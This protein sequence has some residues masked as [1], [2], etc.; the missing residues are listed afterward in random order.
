MPRNCT[1]SARAFVGPTKTSERSQPGKT[2][3]ATFIKDEPS[4]FGMGWVRFVMETPAIF[5]VSNVELRLLLVA[6]A[7][8]VLTRCE[9]DLAELHEFVVFLAA[10]L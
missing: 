6:L 3:L 5:I 8:H 1:F 9:I 2:S 7:A 4:P 10:D